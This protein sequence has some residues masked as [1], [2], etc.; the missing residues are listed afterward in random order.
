MFSLDTKFLKVLKGDDVISIV[1]K[2]K[3]DK[4]DKKANIVTELDF[5]GKFPKVISEIS[6]ILNDQY[7]NEEKI[8]SEENFDNNLLIELYENFR[9]KIE[10]VINFLKQN[11]IEINTLEDY[12]NQLNSLINDIKTYNLTINHFTMMKIN[13]HKY[14]FENNLYKLEK[15][16]EYLKKWKIYNEKSNQ[17]YTEIFSRII[18]SENFKTLYLI[19]MNSSYV[20][21]FVNEQ[22]LNI[23]YNQF[24]K[25]YVGNIEKYVLYV[26]LTMGIKAYVT[27]YFRIAVNINSVDISGT[28]NNKEREEI[29]KSYL[30]INFIKESFHFILRLNKKGNDETQA[31]SPKNKK[32]EEYYED[33]DVDIILYIFGTEYITFISPNNSKLINDLESWRDKTT[34]FKVFDRVYLSHG[35]LVTEKNNNNTKAGLDF[36]ILMDDSNLIN[37]EINYNYSDTIKLCF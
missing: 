29:F 24:M 19:A 18:N 35:K 21:N 16:S 1:T 30:L 11:S 36:N 22:K 9:K 6:K 32:I 15:Y 33:I 17:D 5:I 12:K 26:P 25:E 8:Q 10:K 34:N 27:N 4:S 13:Y 14:F 28:L 23:M 7:D 2:Y 31:L 3:K 20:T 37:Y